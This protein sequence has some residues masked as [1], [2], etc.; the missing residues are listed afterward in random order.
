MM[1]VGVLTRAFFT[2]C[3]IGKSHRWMC[4]V[5]K[6]G[7]YALWVWIIRK[8]SRS[9]QKTFVKGEGPVDQY[10]VT[11][12]FMEFHLGC[13]N[14]DD[15]AKSGRPETINSK[16][17]FQATEAN[18]VSSI[19]WVSGKLSISLSASPSWPR[20]KHLKLTN[21]TKILQKFHNV[22]IILLKIS[23]VKSF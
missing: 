12:W 16:A 6:S 14:L 7:T 17:V 9:N 21:I 1:V 11:R 13:K 22:N 8:R 15:Q 3:M 4:N 10:A 18:P 2:T 20:Q 19:Q 23:C 5:I